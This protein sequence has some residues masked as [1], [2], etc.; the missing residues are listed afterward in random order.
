MVVG[1]GSTR[2]YTL[3]PV[4]TEDPDQQPIAEPLE[5]VES[6]YWDRIHLSVFEQAEKPVN[7]NWTGRKVGQ[8]LGLAGPDEADN[9]NVM[10]EPP[11]SSW[12]TR[13]H[14][15]DDMSLRE[16]AIGPNKED[17]TGVAAGPDTSGT[18][19]VVSG[20]SEGASRG[21]VIEDP[22]GDTY[23][24]KL[25]GP[26]YPELMSSAEVIST[27]ILH[28]AGYYVPQNTVTFFSP[29]QLKIADTASIETGGGEE[30]FGRDDLQ[31]LLEPYEQNARGKIRAL[32]SKFVDGKPLGPFDFYGT[33]SDNPNDRVR[34]EQ[35]RE[36]RGLSVISAWLND[37]DR[38]AANT[39]RVYTDE[40]Y[41]RHYIFDM[42][43]TLGANASGIHR[44]IHGQAYMIDQRKISAALL[45]LGTHRF[46]WWEY[47]PT[48][49]YPSVGYYRADVFKPGEWVMTYPN[50]AFE[51]QTR[52]DA[53]WGAKIVMSFRDE[54]LRA[55]VET[56]QMSNP[57]AESH[58]L[59]VLKSRRDQT[60]RYWF[61]QI[62]PIDRFAIQED[63]TVMAARDG[64][65]VPE[66]PVLTF[67]DLAVTYDL[68]PAD[69]SRY[70]YTMYHQGDRLTAR[71]ST[72]QP[73]ISLR[74]NG[75][76]LTTLLDQRGASSGEE[77]VV[78]VD[79]QTHR[80]DGHVS[81]ETR[82]YVHLPAQER[83][84]VVG[85][86]RP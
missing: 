73:A 72:H 6:M 41:V 66:G 82:V 28:A 16:L 40:E 44:P 57:Q 17:A 46:P 58:L 14:Y 12:Y 80:P 29:D 78:R 1:C 13:R 18:W 25:D 64:T 53:F 83:P 31:A 86:E 23:V 47:D 7:L 45:G 61:R 2:P 68:E 70:T 81:R 3:G 71:Q 48:P 55:I 37:T 30:P 24:M 75:S 27:K 5:T 84:R 50:P 85:I 36:L 51:K 4:K 35:R 63:G 38:R 76:S 52:R 56:A 60:G 54:D 74:V 32:A 65:R 19:T 8:A 79:L 43:S 26:K 11:N 62:N 33:N 21:F 9:V 15:Y 59:D 20:K 49:Q 42:G 39:L 69:G 10:D 34:H 77:R 67:D 22:Q